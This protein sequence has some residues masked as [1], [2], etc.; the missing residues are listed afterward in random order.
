MHDLYVP[1]SLILLLFF[2]FCFV[3]LIINK[4]LEKVEKQLK[5]MDE[6]AE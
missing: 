5:K 3:I 4:R 1:N 2:V 6:K